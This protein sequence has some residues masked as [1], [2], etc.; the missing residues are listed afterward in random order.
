MS[1]SG[2]VESRLEPRD[3]CD[4]RR[5][6]VSR[7]AEPSLGSGTLTVPRR[8]EVSDNVLHAVKWRLLE[9]NTLSSGLA[10]SVWSGR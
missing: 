5:L 8:Y 6:S 4:E 2:N 1:A 9:E 3:E 7:S 10:A